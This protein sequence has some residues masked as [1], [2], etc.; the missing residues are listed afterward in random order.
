MHDY[1]LI[2]NNEINKHEKYKNQY[3]KNNTY[4]G[5]G[6]E[7][8]VYLEFENKR[9]INKKDFINNHKRERYSID[10]FSNYKSNELDNAFKYIYNIINNNIEIPIMLNSNSFT[11]TDYNNNSKTLYTKNVKIIQN[12]TEIH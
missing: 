11:K 1:I 6:I 10:Y 7:N 4:W 2:G 5:L 12:L 9:T 8:E 3:L